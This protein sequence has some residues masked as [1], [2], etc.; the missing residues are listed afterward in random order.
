MDRRAVLGKSKAE[1]V[2]AR[3]GQAMAASYLL[4]L[5]PV[6]PVVVAYVALRKL[7]ALFTSGSGERRQ[8]EPQIGTQSS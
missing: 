6:L 7:V 3:V 4:L 5:L 2:M 1:L 8:Y